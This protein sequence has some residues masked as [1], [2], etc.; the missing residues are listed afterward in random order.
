MTAEQ[1][2]EMRTTWSERPDPV[3]MRRNYGAV[4]DRARRGRFRAPERGWP[5]ELV[6]AHLLA[7]NELFLR[8]G[9]GV[10][11]GERPDCGGEEAVA[12]EE[13][14]RRA[15]EAGGL[16]ELARRL[17]RSAERL[18]AHAESLTDAEARTPVRFR[19]VHE[20]QVMVDEDRP[21]GTI[22]DG[23]VGFHLPLHLKQLEDLAAT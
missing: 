5:A 15:A 19:V 18:A 13:L 6:L 11:R 14:A 4:V 20:G 21:W 7:T 10:K 8:V 17:E 16:E 23:Q 2:V 9:E 3:E 1:P 22:L 12:D